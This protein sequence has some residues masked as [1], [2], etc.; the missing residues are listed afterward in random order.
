MHVRFRDHLPK[1]FRFVL[2]GTITAGFDVGVF[3]VTMKLTE[4]IFISTTLSFIVAVG[5]N[6]FGH[7]LFTFRSGIGAGN[8]SRY[9]VVLVFQYCLSLL[10][11]ATFSW[12]LGN[13][14]VGK[15]ISIAIIVPLSFLLSNIYVFTRGSQTRP[16]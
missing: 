12:M 8:L 10:L 9:I 7:S 1:I 14:L 13:A 11:I 5:V 4:S 2:I 16:R 3:Y 15:L 6:Y